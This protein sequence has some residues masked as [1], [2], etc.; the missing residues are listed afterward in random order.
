VLLARRLD[1]GFDALDAERVDELVLE[2]RRAPV[3]A[4]TLIVRQAGGRR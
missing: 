1:D 2:I 3:E 4:Q